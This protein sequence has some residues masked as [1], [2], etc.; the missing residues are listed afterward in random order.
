M[1]KKKSNEILP[2]GSVYCINKYFTIDKINQ[3]IAAIKKCGLNS[4]MLW[5]MIE[6]DTDKKVPDFTRID[7]AVA[8]C[9]KHGLALIPELLGEAHWLEFAPMWR[10]VECSDESIWITYPD[11]ETKSRFSPNKSPNLNHPFVQNL[12]QEYLELVVNRYKNSKALLYWNIWDEPFFATVDKLT[13]QK[14]RECLQK[15]YDTIHLLNETW[16]QTWTEWEQVEIF[17]FGWF[18][19]MPQIDYHLFYLQNTAE[20]LHFIASCVKKADKE[21]RTLCHQVGSMISKTSEIEADDWQMAKEVDIYGTSFYH[22]EENPSE[23]DAPWH[24]A[25]VFSNIRSAAATK[26]F[27]LAEVQSHQRT[28]YS[29]Y[30]Q[31]SRADIEQI[32]WQAIAQ[33]GKGTL[34][35][36]WLP[37]YTGQQSLGRGLTDLEGNPTERAYAAGEAAKVIDAYGEDMLEATLPKQSIAVHYD[38]MN[39]IRTRLMAGSVTSPDHWLNKFAKMNVFGV[40]RD[41]WESGRNANFICSEEIA[42]GNLADISFLLSSY[43]TIISED[44]EKVLDSWI[45]NGGVFI[46]DA[47]FAISDDNDI[48]FPKPPGKLLN[49]NWGINFT[50]MNATHDSLAIKMTTNRFEGTA[51]KLNSVMDGGPF[52]IDF[53]YD[54]CWDVLGVYLDSGAPAML[55]RSYGKGRIYLVGLNLGAPCYDEKETAIPFWSS[56]LSYHNHKIPVLLSPDA[57]AMPVESSL[58]KTSSDV[59]YLVLLNWGESAVSTPVSIDVPDHVA[60]VKRIYPSDTDTQISISRNSDRLCFT[61]NM[62]ARETAVFRLC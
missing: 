9:E 34:F 2:I 51:L 57:R 37:F 15:K 16:G 25:A 41:L 47:R 3:D 50:A 38:A 39:D 44:T 13:M 8:A 12:L 17:T 48:S 36:K 24:T 21:H 19:L 32:I 52:R 26:S 54:D 7:A 58:L 23:I 60:Q 40:Y 14:F 27:I 30:G 11:I 49:H 10:M 1:D 31:M 18:S 55:T 4:I 5:P 43:Q 56:L 35:W 53:N 29:K 46:A 62:K 20:I 59:W 42:S 33:Q 6:W 61:L 28:G 22:K 45:M